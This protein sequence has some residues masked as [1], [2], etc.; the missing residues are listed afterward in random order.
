MTK[1]LYDPSIPTS[2]GDADTAAAARKP[3]NNIVQG[4]SAAGVRAVGTQLVAFYFRAPVKAFFRMRVDYMQMVRAV[5]PLIQAGERWSFRQTTPLLL[6]HAVK[7]YGW[8]FIPNQVLPPLIAN[9]SVGALLYTT[10]LTT[11]STLHAPSSHH[12]RRVHPPPP[13]T[14]TFT[15]GLLAGTLQSI[16]A[17][18]LDALVIRFKVSEMLTGQY[19]SMWTYAHHKLREIGPRGVFAGYGLSLL[20]ESLGYGVFF[21]AFEGVKQ[22]GFYGYARWYYGRGLRPGEETTVRPHFTMEPAFLLAAGMAASVCQ[23]VVQHPLGKV[24]DVHWGRLESMDYA[25]KLVPQAWRVYANAYRDTWVQC[26]LQ[27][28]KVGGWARWLYRGFVMNTLRQ[29]P[30]TSAGLIVFELVRRRYA[31]VGEEAAIR[32]EGEDGG[33]VTILLN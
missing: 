12:S 25:A 10:Y 24:Q 33:V 22:Q 28:E 4:T 27:K 1:D 2:R 32:V 20:K 8:G 7:H 5:N 14:A 26:A 29:V 31:L 3:A 13:P 11:L 9:A 19:S 18:P 21:A 17:A 6:A 23:Q 15:A 30:S 16:V